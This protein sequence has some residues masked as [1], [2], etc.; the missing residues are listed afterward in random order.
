MLYIAAGG[1]AQYVMC[2][3]ISC[4]MIHTVF[5]KQKESR[6]QNMIYK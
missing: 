3:V 2:M 6:I 1:T 4:L 5:E